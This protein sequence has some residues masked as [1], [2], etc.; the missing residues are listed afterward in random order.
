M[1]DPVT[2]SGGDAGGEIVEGKD[3]LE[4]ETRQFGG[5]L[6]RRAGAQ[7]IFVGPAAP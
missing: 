1:Q 3:W 4:G 2:L 5:G 6:Y 7:G